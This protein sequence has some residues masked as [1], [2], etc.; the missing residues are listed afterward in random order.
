[1]VDARIRAWRENP[2]PDEVARRIAA[3]VSPNY[4]GDY[5]LAR[6]RSANIPEE[7]NCSVWITGLPPHIN[8]HQL[9]GAIRDTGR[10]WATVVQPPMTASVTS[11]AKITFFTPDA[12]QTL[13]QRANGP[14]KPG[15]VIDDQKALVRRDRNRVAEASEPVEHTRV[16]S[17]AGPTD[18]VTEENLVE[19]FRRDFVFEL[20]QVVPLVMGRALNVIEFHFG[21][22]RC[23]AQWAW[24]NILNDQQFRERG[25]RV[26]FER[27]PCDRH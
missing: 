12:A 9:L 7:L 1:M 13:L 5:R 8:T 17:V 20:D 14:G 19:F 3:G 16:I 2:T 24:R 15:L 4:R 23:Q 27:D 21:S 18:V 26:Q 11:A 6:N 25:V 22:Y 10:V